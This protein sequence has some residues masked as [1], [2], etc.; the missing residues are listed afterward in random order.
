[1][2]LALAAA[3]AG[4]IAIGYIVWAA[5]LLLAEVLVDAAIVSAVSRQLVDDRRDWT[6]TAIRR[7]WLPATIVVASLVVGGWALQKIAPDAKSIGPALRAIA[8]R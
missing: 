4:L 2:L 8:N 7:T 3:L 5:P 1:M 6:A